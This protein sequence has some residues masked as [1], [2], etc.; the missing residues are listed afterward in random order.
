MADGYG[1]IIDWEIHLHDPEEDR[2]YE[3]EL[4]RLGWCL[5]C[6]GYG[7]SWEDGSAC[8]ECLGTGF[9]NHKTTTT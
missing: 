8:G 2:K 7:Q 9:F 5:M 6:Q 4:K 3:D 1:N